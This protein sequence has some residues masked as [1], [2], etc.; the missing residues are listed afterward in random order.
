LPVKT[1]YLFI[2][3]ISFISIDSGYKLAAVNVKL[4]QLKKFNIRS[5]EFCKV[6][7]KMGTI[8]VCEYYMIYTSPYYGYAK[9]I[10]PDAGKLLSKHLN[11][12]STVESSFISS[13]LLS[14]E[15]KNVFEDNI[16]YRVSAFLYFR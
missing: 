13:Q 5:S 15:T 12:R 1:S 8:R 14:L 6:V 7:K 16:T 3:N 4:R 2:F 9:E 10:L 11:T